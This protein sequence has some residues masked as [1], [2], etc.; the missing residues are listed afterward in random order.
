MGRHAQDFEETLTYELYQVWLN[1]AEVSGTL[2]NPNAFC[3]LVL[4]QH[5]Y[6]LKPTSFRYHTRQMVIKGVLV[7]DQLTGAIHL[8]EL[9]VRRR[10][11]LAS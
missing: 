11:R 10:K 3:T 7:F 1:H 5:D 9:E 2:V 6:H 4:P 8:P